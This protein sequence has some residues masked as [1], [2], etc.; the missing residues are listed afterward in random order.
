MPCLSDMNH[1]STHG[2]EGLVTYC[3]S[4]GRLEEAKV[5]GS[6]RNFFFSLPVVLDFFFILFLALLY[7]SIKLLYADRATLSSI[8]MTGLSVPQHQS[9]L[10]R[11]LH[12]K[13][14]VAVSTPHSVTKSPFC[15]YAFN[16]AFS[17][18]GTGSGQLLF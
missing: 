3:C 10:P 13:V 4:T 5:T 15:G 17:F 11:R 2:E 7:W 14:S 18:H 16:I 8:R 1:S 6:V 9:A 12:T